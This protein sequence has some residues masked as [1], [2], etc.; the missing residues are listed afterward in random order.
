MECSR[1]ILIVV[2]IGVIGYRDNLVD[3]PLEINCRQK[4]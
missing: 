4:V 3:K 2:I 1:D